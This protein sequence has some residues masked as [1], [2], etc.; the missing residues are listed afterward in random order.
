MALRLEMRYKIID[1]RILAEWNA[2]V[3]ETIPAAAKP[4]KFQ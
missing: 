2:N 3:I 4:N 1:F